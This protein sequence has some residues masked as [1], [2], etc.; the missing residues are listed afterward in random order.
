MR[1]TVC[2]WIYP[3]LVKYQE[4]LLQSFLRFSGGSGELAT[5]KAGRGREGGHR[6]WAS[7]ASRWTQTVYKSST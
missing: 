4:E 2:V 5:M 1:R 6:V 3:G 7:A